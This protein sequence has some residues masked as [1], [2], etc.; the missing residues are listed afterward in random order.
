MHNSLIEYSEEWILSSISLR[1][2]RHIK[3]SNVEVSREYCN[4]SR[5]SR[6]RFLLS[7]AECATFGHGVHISNNTLN[8]YNV[9]LFDYKINGWKRK[10][11]CRSWNCVLSI[12]VL[13]ILY[14]VYSTSSFFTESILKLRFCFLMQRR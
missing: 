2:S 12:C 3:Y 7:A 13:V 6:E 10:S 11:D 14:C 4:F 1:I 5:S 9:Q 8:L